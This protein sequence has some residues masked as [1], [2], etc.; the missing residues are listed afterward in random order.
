MMHFLPVHENIILD[1]VPEVQSHNILCIQSHGEESPLHE[2]E[3]MLCRT[4]HSLVIEGG[5]ATL[6]LGFEDIRQEMVV[7]RLSHLLILHQ[8]I[9]SIHT[10]LSVVVI[11]PNVYAITNGLVL[12]ERG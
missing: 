1:R 12:I 4:C 6:L 3:G 11:A 2:E 9:I 7:S 10:Q 5:D 8:H